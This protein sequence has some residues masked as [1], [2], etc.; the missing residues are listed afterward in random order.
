MSGGGQG[1][2]Y[3]QGDLSHVPGMNSRNVRN[4]VR[5]GDGIELLMGL[6]M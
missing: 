4:V 5:S 1:R 2:C 3:F 6:E